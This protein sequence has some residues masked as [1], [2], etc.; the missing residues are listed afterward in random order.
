[1]KEEYL[2]RAVIH[3]YFK[4][5]LKNKNEMESVVILT[6]DDKVS[7]KIFECLEGEDEFKDWSNLYYP[8]TQQTDYVE[9]VKDFL[10]NP[11]GILVT[12]YSSFQG[13]QARN[14]ILFIEKETDKQIARSMVLRSM[15]LAII[16][17]NLENKNFDIPGIVEDKD[18]YAWRKGRLPITESV[19]ESMKAT[20]EKVNI[21]NERMERQF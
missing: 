2:T 10:K 9:K 11:H 7:K 8:S 17:H 3:K 5:H 21:I 6:T 16:I 13:V 18:L 20:A 4:K 14:V 19:L 1:M 12:T 15:A